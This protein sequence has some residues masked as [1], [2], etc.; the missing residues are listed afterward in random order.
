MTV[1]VLGIR[2]HGPGSARAL[3]ASLQEWA[4]DAVLVEGPPEADG[5]LGLAG[6]ATMKPTVAL[7]G[8]L[9]SH[10]ARA[11][12]WPLSAWSP[13]WVAVQYALASN[14]TVKMIDLPAAVMLAGPADH[15]TAAPVHGDP[16]ARLA[17]AAGYDDTERWWEDMVE[18]RQGEEPWEAIAEAVAELRAVAEEVTGTEA[19][20]E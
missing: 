18:H 12:F 3:A 11:A 6:L 19:R 10:P 17:E 16:L 13:E 14:V 15:D 5:V 2:H 1:R 9:P 7:L 4:P 20:R 8:Y